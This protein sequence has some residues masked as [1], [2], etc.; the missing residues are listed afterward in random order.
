MKKTIKVL[1]II[2]TL[3]ILCSCGSTTNKTNTEPS[4]APTNTNYD[5]R[6]SNW[7][8]S[9]ESVIQKEGEPDYQFAETE[10]IVYNDI[11]LL[12]FNSNL[13]YLFQNKQLS[14]ASYDIKDTHTNNQLYID[15]YEKIKEELNK[16]HG[17]PINP[18]DEKWT[19]DLWKDDPGM[20]LMMSEL[21]FSSVYTKEGKVSIIHS[22]SCDNFEIK[23]YIYYYSPDY[24]PDYR[25]EVNNG[26]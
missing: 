3:L 14:S 23:H 20:A 19:G 24:D 16:K 8:D 4:P 26:L 21:S 11:E 5:F 12:S 6:I 18:D 7:G 1:S 22:L 25:T 9:M 10:S 2:L 13:T 17:E 15:D